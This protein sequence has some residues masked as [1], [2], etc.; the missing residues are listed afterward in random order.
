MHAKQKFVRN[1][2]FLHIAC[3]TVICAKSPIPAYCMP[4]SDLYKIPHSWILHANQWFVRSPPVLHIACQTLICAKSPFLLIACQTVICAFLHIKYL[5]LEQRSCVTPK[6]WVVHNNQ[7]VF[8]GK[9]IF[10]DLYFFKYQKFKKLPELEK[11]V[12]GH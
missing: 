3:Q 2:P 6:F 8:W 12:K 10:L 5:F 1:L 11:C 4:N 7:W 9:T